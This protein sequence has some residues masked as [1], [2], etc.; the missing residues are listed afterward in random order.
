MAERIPTAVI[1]EVRQ[2]VN[3]VDVI[4]QYT[5]LSKRGREW[6]G[7]CPFHEDR[8]PSLFVDDK[9]QVFHCFSCGRSGTVFS[10]IMEKEGLS[11]PEAV[12][13]LAQ[14][15]GISIDQRYTSGGSNEYGQRFAKVFELYTA[16][17]RLY[18]HI[19]LNTTAGEE[20]LKYLEE[21]R[22]LDQATIQ[23][24]GIGYVPEDNAFLHYVEEQNIDSKLRDESNLFL[25]N[26]SGQTRDRF[27]RRVVW[28]IANAQGQVVGFSGRTLD[29]DNQIKYM[30]SPESSFF[31][32]S[33]LLYHFDQAKS[34]IR[35]TKTAM[36][37]EGFMDVISANL[38]GEEIGVATM[39]TALTA[40]HV[41]QLARIAQKILLLYDGDE[42]G[43]K[44]AKRSIALINEEAPKVEI[45]IVVLPDDLD[46]DEMRLQ[47]G[48]PALQKAME[49]GVLTPTEF[50]VQAARTGR[51]LSNQAQYLD[52]LK[53]ILP[54]LKKA[55]PI[56]QE[57]Q[58]NRLTEEF[59]TSKEALKAQLA[60]V[61]L[62]KNPPAS[63]EGGGGNQYRSQPMP[64]IE[65]T[66]DLS[67][68]TAEDSVTRI[69]QAERGLIMA[70]IKSPAVMSHVKSL[71]DFTFVHPDYQLIM[72]LIEVYQST[73]GGDFN[74]ASFM[75]FIQ[76]PELNQ[77]LI[78]IDQEYGDLA[79]QREAV[80]DYLN[81]I[82]KEAPFDQA[83]ENLRQGIRIAKQQHDDARLIELTTELIKLKRQQQKRR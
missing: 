71:P 12:I 73:V 9:K 58:L 45:G 83:V 82:M 42:A 74:L 23:K 21:K 30:N 6:N 17:Q 62:P 38:A 41:R 22:G 76:K 31:N 19:L 14:E 7:S 3:I 51:N 27:A 24:Y 37:L 25:T 54:I 80:D 65:D 55:G 2:K 75:D 66:P 67:D 13:K 35:T 26:D 46:P 49:Q 16:A 63:R 48:L 34:S 53:E 4:G 28:P 79:V 59:G 56:E 40:Y 8:R 36:I 50:L 5:Q 43:Q 29:P 52:F 72:M 44:A 32:K 78:R 11:Y 68:I 18:Q 64:A 70:M 61:V 57:T 77:K 81:I 47:R 10:F 39:G 20:A 33:Q 15:A 1:D 60:E 69:E